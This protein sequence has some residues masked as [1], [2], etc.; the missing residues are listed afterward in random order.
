MLA[1]DIKGAERE[2]LK[3]QFSFVLVFI[4]LEKIRFCLS[5]NLDR[6]S[7]TFSFGLIVLMQ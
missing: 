5:I 3:N 6:I 2:S 7:I 1:N 4:S